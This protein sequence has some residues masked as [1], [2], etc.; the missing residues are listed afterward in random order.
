VAA[1]SLFANR[2]RALPIAQVLADCV[3]GEMEEGRKAF[4]RY[5]LSS[6]C[7]ELPRK[8]TAFLLM[9]APAVIQQR[10]EGISL[11]IAEHSQNRR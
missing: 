5:P 10:F 7:F 8:T 9:N 11:M 4:G 3:D 6:C 2:E 1:E